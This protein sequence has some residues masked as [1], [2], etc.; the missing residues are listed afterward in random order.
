MIEGLT[1]NKTTPFDRL[2]MWVEVFDR[3]DPELVGLSLQ[4]CLKGPSQSG[5]GLSGVRSVMA[6]GAGTR[7]RLWSFARH[8]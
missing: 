6:G 8:E 2:S 7:S 1:N 5:I 4:S 3:L